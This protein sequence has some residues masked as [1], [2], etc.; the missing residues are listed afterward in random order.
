MDHDIVHCVSDTIYREFIAGA[1]VSELHEKYEGYAIN[2]LL[3][4]ECVRKE[5]EIDKLR[6]KNDCF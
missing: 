5:I 3:R 2:T 4:Y 6:K 1:T